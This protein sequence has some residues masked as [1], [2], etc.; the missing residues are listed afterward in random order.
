MDI[1][2]TCKGC[3]GKSI[4]DR[5]GASCG[6]KA[7]TRCLELLR[8]ID[9]EV[10]WKTVNKRQRAARKARTSFPGEDR[11]K[12]VIRSFYACPTATSREEAQEDAPISESEKVFIS[13]I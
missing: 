12:A 7:N 11:M 8:P 13:T 10:R 9:P 3:G 1:L 6:S 4:V 5:G 2:T